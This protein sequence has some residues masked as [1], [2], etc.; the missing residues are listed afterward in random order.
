VSAANR[1]L[2]GASAGNTYDV[3]VELDT[4][5]RTVDVPPDLAAALAKDQQA[6]AAFDA[7]SYSH[8]RQHVEAIAGAKKQE[9]RQRRI[10]KTLAMLRGEA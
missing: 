5:P 10:D 1:E 4:A 8:Q 7:L 9:T 6:R 2:T 3:D